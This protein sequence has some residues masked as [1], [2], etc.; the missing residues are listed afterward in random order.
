MAFFA[1]LVII[2]GIRSIGRVAEKIV[3]FMCGAYIL[4]AIYIILTHHDRIIPSFYRIFN[5]AFRWESAFGGFLGVMVV[6]IKRAVF[7][8]EAGVGS[9]AIAHSAARTQW[10]IREGMVALL[11]PFIDTVVVCTMSALVMVITGVFERPEFRSLVERDQGAALMKE[12]FVDGGHYWFRWVLYLA[13]VLFAYSTLI[14]WSYYGERCW[15]WLFGPRLSLVYKIIFLAFCVLGSIVQANN[16]LT[17]S[18]LL[19]LGMSFPNILGL[20]LLSSRV[21]AALDDYWVRLKRGEFEED[22]RRALEFRRRRQQ[23]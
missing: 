13:V 15:T 14:S 22:R 19:I 10:P 11:E 23:G 5:E 4:A 16:I 20:I 21:R 7:S 1:G 17:F 18:D 2:G 8:N 9:A 3:P 12:A 6:G